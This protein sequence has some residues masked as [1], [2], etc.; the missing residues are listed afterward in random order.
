[1]SSA[2]MNQLGDLMQRVMDD[3]AAERRQSPMGDSPVP[4]PRVGLHR[5]VPPEHYHAWAAASH[6]R[7]CT[8]EVSPAHLRAGV[9]KLSK[10][11]RDMG[12]AIHAAILEWDR[13][14]R[15]YAQAKQ[16]EATTGKGT[17][18]SK[19]GT[20]VYGGQWLCSTHRPDIGE[21]EC[22]VLNPTQT[23]Q[24][25]AAREAVMRHPEARRL[26][27][28]EWNEASAYW[29]DDEFGVPCKARI[30]HINEVEDCTVELKTTRDASHEAFGVD[31]YKFRYYRQGAW[32]LDALRRFDDVLLLNP[33]HRII[34]VEYENPALPVVQ[35]YRVPDWLLQAGH[36]EQRTL[37]ARYAECVQ[38][39]HWPLEGERYAAGERELF[40]PSRAT[41]EIDSR[42]NPEGE[43]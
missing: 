41:Y 14:Q 25:L 28:G 26:L 1:M 24:V 38:R 8:V 40:V 12:T 21:S 20:G 11:T 37:L 4:Q 30:D 23:Q 33:T 27:A 42:L 22:F 9:E 35:V 7:L 29:I 19:L 17:Q 39:N 43:E 13:F 6:S 16:C 34:A 2:A 31:A 15:E 36:L 32:Y 18:C 10:W 3:E 5:D